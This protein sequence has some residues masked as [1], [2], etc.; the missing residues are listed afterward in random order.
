MKYEIEK[1]SGTYDTP[2]FLS[3][4]EASLPLLDERRVEWFYRNHPLSPPHVYLLKN[5]ATENYFGCVAIF[6]RYF[7]VD[8]KIVNGGTTGDMAAKKEVRSVGAALIPMLALTRFMLANE[9]DEGTLLLGFPNRISEMIQIRVGF[10]SVGTMLEYVKPLQSASFLKNKRLSRLSPVVDLLLRFSELKPKRNKG[11]FETGILKKLD[12]RFDHLWETAQSKFSFAGNRDLAY[13]QLRYLQNPYKKHHF[14]V[15]EAPQKQS[16]VG[17]IVFAL[18]DRKVSVD[19]LFWNGENHVLQHLIDAFIQF[20][21]EK[22][23]LGIYIQVFHN[24]QLDSILKQSGFMKKKTDA[25]LL[26][27]RLDILTHNID[28]IL[29]TSGDNDF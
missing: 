4:W 20:C 27:N 21:R 24:S 16:I 13:L 8:G 7:V 28:K 25:K 14:F 18:K 19:D 2:V 9:N 10:K 23:Y 3:I 22:S 12:E 11:L 15:I 5:T 17:Y 1:I 26:T 29:L 6:P